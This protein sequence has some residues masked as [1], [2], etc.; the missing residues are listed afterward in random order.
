MIIRDEDEQ[1][2]LII[3]QPGEAERT[4]P[5][6]KLPLVIGRG[7][8]SDILIQHQVVSRQHAR[9]EQEGQEYWI[10]DLKST[11][12]TLLNNHKITRHQLKD[13]DIIRIGDNQGNSVGLTFRKSV[14]LQHKSETIDLDERLDFLQKPLV[15]IGRDPSNDIHLNHPSVSRGHAEV[16]QVARGHELRDLNS[17]NGTFVNGK[18]LSGTVLLQERDVVQIGPFKL[19][20][21]HEGLTQHTLP[22]NYRLDAISLTR[23]VSSADGFSLKRLFGLNGG[24]TRKII[25][26]DI[27]LSVY[28][29]EFVALVGGSG[30]GKSTL[31][32]AL[33]GF[34][35]AKGQ[36]LVNGEDLYMNFDAYRSILG[37]V[38]Q[39]DIIHG[40][41][42]VRGVLTYSAELRLPDAS[43]EEIKQRVDYVLSEVEMSEHEQKQV[44][45]LSGGQRKRVSI[46]VELLA[47]PGLF[48]LDEPTS[49]LDPGLEKKL[50]Y[51]M[52][53]LADEGRTILLVTHATANINQ[54]TQVA[55]LA[56]GRL[57]YFGPPK[58]ALTFF[59]ASDFADIYT[60]LSQNFSADRKSLP[61]QLQPYYQQAKANHPDSLLA[62]ELWGDYFKNSAPYKRYVAGRIRGSGAPA[63]QAKT[64]QE[65]SDVRSGQ[66]VSTWQQFRVLT[67]RYFELVRRDTTRLTILLLVMPIIGLLLLM[68]LP[69]EPEIREN[70]LIEAPLQTRVSVIE[71]EIA[72]KNNV[73]IEDE[74]LAGSFEVVTSAQRLLFMMALAVSLLGIFAAAYEIINERGIYS[75][76]RLVNLKIMPYLF[77]KIAVLA[78]FALLQCLLLLVVIGFAVTYPSQGVFLPS[79][80]EMYIT[81]FLASLAAITLGLLVS[82]ALRSTDTVIYVVLLILFAQILFGGAIFE[83]NGPT[84]LLSYTTTTRWTL[85]GLGSTVNMQ[86]LKEQGAIC[87]EF[88]A[89][90]ARAELPIPE[91]PCTKGQLKQVPDFKFNLDYTHTLAYLISRWLVLLAFTAAF[92]FLTALVQRRKDVV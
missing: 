49:G 73:D 47:E 5:L 77:S 39:D 55:F 16:K 81:L 2:R 56:N 40:Q 64:Q 33:S 69:K 23:V 35:P 22:G 4:V 52:R 26:D 30:A 37:Y 31:I 53:R 90:P 82:A 1:P 60:R 20:Y 36:V 14:T 75:R 63:A 61:P 3:E 71:S 86:A 44:S 91:P 48:F 41:L 18:R 66:R 72:L 92:T 68:T 74:Q 32:K 65:E 54:C 8:A 19:V 57:M 70:M 88:E 9:L 87:I 84:E 43:A 62:S 38:P 27:S 85:D 21:D 76:E 15:I 78:L 89:P 17:S 25:L 83:L 42:T 58:E 7:S 50:M 28:P 6:V 11:N 67:R 45:R 59:G 29:K 10:S 24:S 51:T 13:G 12:G 80:L 46:A 79:M 34:V